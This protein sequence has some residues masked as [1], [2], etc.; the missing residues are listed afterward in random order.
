MKTIGVTQQVDQPRT[1][2][3]VATRSIQ[4]HRS[5]TENPIWIQR[6]SLICH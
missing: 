5:D 2:N 4:N 1:T 3:G 6:M